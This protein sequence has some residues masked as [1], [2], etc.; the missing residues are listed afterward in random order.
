MRNPFAFYVIGDSMGP[1]IDHGDQVV[2][3]PVQPPQ[4][5][6]DCVFIH[7]DETGQMLALVKR[8]LK[9]NATSWRV[10]QFNPAK[11]FDLPKKKWAKALMIAEK[12]IGYLRDDQ[13]S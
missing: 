4:P 3:H 1:A 10:R 13:T 7:E 12:R 5:G 8:L 6:R 9:S 11:D 2:V